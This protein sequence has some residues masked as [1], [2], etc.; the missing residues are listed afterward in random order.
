[1]NV[2]EAIKLIISAGVVTPPYHPLKT[3]NQTT[4]ANPQQ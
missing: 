4:L 2:T 1:M 3:E